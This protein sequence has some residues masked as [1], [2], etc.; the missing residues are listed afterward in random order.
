MTK[1]HTLAAAAG[2]AVIGS[3]HALT[4]AQLDSL[5]AGGSL[6]EFH[7]SGASALRLSLGAYVQ[8][9]CTP[10]TFD[11]FF[12]SSTGSNH[13]AYSCAL[14][15]TVGNFA[16]GTPVIVYK[17]DQGGSGQGVNPVALATP[18]AAMV[19]SAAGCTATAKA[20]P[21][22]DLQ[23]PTF[24]CGTTAS[25]VSDT[26]ISDVEPALLQA[27][28]N[29][30]QGTAPLTG[31]QLNQLNV[32][33]LAQGIFGVAVNKKLY[34]ALQETQGIISAAAPI[35]DVPAD[36]ST[37]TDSTLAT[38]PNLPVEFVR[39]VLLGSASGGTTNAT[40]K[41]GWNL[42][43]SA[44]VDGNVLTKTLNICRRVEGSG[45]QASSNAFFATNPCNATS[46]VASPL[47]V[48]GSSGNAPTQRVT[49]PAF[50]VRESSGTGG[51]ETCLGSTTVNGAD[52]PVEAANDGDGVAYGL[53]V[54]SRE[55][56][57]KANGGDKGYRFV[58]LDN[59][60]PT[61]LAAKAGQYGFVYESTMQWNKAVVP[62]GSDDEAFL[63]SLRS[64]IGKPTSLAS[65]DID[66]QQ[67]L[68]S[69]PA[70][71]TGPY[72]DQTGASALFAS[73]VARLSN[74]SCFPLRV[75]K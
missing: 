64:N 23:T 37:W 14:K 58:K 52:V 27:P 22:T 46:A 49:G 16:A 24:I 7:V 5:R 62:A 48:S 54:I 21:A 44:G 41:R 59:L 55:N 26:G 36:Q 15:Q 18:I 47:S 39:A 73:S 57:P 32:A 68:M 65:A 35:L 17:R 63:S 33:P 3:A 53:G 11:V 12:D 61:R 10:A 67:G 29:L 60:A 25:V 51:V 9:I 70:S 31:T 43:V 42:V 30:P 75:V 56:N 28:V 1:L 6:K 50:V 69:P 20:P 45:T 4:P 34:R 40:Q 72:V 66:T 38:I 8:E 13:R 2:L 71:Y 74:N 19:V